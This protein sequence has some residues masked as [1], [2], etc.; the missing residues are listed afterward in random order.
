MTVHVHKEHDGENVEP[1]HLHCPIT[2]VMFK[3]PVMLVS[4]GHTYERRAILRHLTLFNSDPVTN[5]KIKN[6]AVVVNW[7]VRKSVEQWLDNHP[8]VVPFGWKDRCVSPPADHSILQE[9]VRDGTVPRIKDLIK[10]GA[11]IN[12]QGEIYGCSALHVCLRFTPR[13]KQEE[14]FKI[15]L[16]NGA[17]VNSVGEHGYTL[18]HYCA[19]DEKIWDREYVVR[20]LISKGAKVNTKN[21]FGYTP[22][23]YCASYGNVEVASLLLDAGADVNAKDPF[24]RTPLFPDLD[25]EIYDY[26]KIAR[27]Q[28]DAGANINRTDS[29][30]M[31]PLHVC[32]KEGCCVEIT[33]GLIAL[34]SDVNATDKEKNTVLHICL[35]W[36]V[37]NEWVVSHVKCLLEAGADVNAQDH[38]GMTPLD[39]CAENAYEIDV[40]DILIKAGANV[41]TKDING[42]T[43]LHKYSLFSNFTYDNEREEFIN[44]WGCGGSTRILKT[45]VENGARINEKDNEGLTPLHIC[46]NVDSMEFL[47]ESGADLHARTNKGE[48]ALHLCAKRCDLVL[49]KALIDA[50]TNLSLKD[51]Y[52]RTFLKM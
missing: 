20:A 10:A 13:N 14:V 19:T 17:D 45:L 42:S 39:I 23:S 36:G 48:T 32:A 7:I 12:A 41:N 6:N 49:V 30:G 46:R 51:M 29:Y 47:I 9:Y 40:F 2:Q 35:R 24:G 33:K 38:N 15:L 11:D 8:D 18:L 5:R 21:V 50:G 44:V 27:L 26:I 1:D 37:H 22:L 31:T 52:G 4:S 34:G 3:D 43:P 28:L 25:V 16:N